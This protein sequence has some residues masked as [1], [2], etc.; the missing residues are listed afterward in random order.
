MS[1]SNR[2]FPCF[3]AA[4]L[5]AAAGC[6]RQAR[7]P[8]GLALD[9]ADRLFAVAQFEEARG[10]YLAV[11]A[12]DPRNFR[13]RVRLGEIALLQNRN[14]E[15]ERWL[16]EAAAINGSSNEPSRLLAEVY[17]RSR[18]FD[19]SAHY[20]RRI[21]AETTASKLTYLSSRAPYQVDG[22]PSVRVRL[23]ATDPLPLVAVQVNG[24]APAN[25]LIDTGAA[26]V[27]LD[28]EFAREV[29]ATEFG[30]STGT[31]AADQKA[32]VIQAAID[33]IVIGECRVSR[34]P[35]HLLPTRRF[36]GL[37]QGKRVDGV[38][39]TRFLYLF[40]AT[41]DYPN[42]ELELSQPQGADLPMGESAAIDVPVWLAGDHYLVAEG[43]ANGHAMLFF[44]DTGLAELAF[45]AP[46]STLDVAH[47]A[48][49]P[50]ERLGGLGGGGPIS[51]V[52]FTVDELALG[53]A[54]AHRAQG[55]A[56]VFPSSLENKFGFRIGGLISHAFFRPYAVTFDFARMLL[57]LRRTG[58]IEQ[59]AK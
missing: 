7:P 37:Y 33:S 24:S 25:F 19:K 49:R 22:P 16:L 10:R 9:E 50:D 41:V 55:V 45:A 2:I 31:F 26:E 52:R 4:L 20:F 3:T 48:T 46:A 15:A 35:V 12:G 14:P 56:G 13:A 32:E 6:V 28:R 11:A 43:A 42:G 17:Y 18:A 39:G 57:H 38:I 27:I 47:I 36:S 54:V 1:V 40:A 44:V 59:S 23:V 51:A 58:R 8:T 5:L 29:G 34:V 53:G 30:A 21:G